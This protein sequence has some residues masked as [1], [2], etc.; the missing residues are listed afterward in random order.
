MTSIDI[1]AHRSRIENINAL[2]T[3]P[4]TLK[5]ISSIIEKPKLTLDE[6]SH[7]ISNDPALASRVLKMVNSAIYGFPGRISSVSHA[8]MLLGLNVVKG[9][10]LGTSIFEIMQKVMNGLWDHSMGCAV[11]SRV[12]AEKLG[13]KYPEEVSVA[14]LLHDLGKVILILEYQKDYEESIGDAKEKGIAISEAE[15]IHFQETHAA[16]GM[17]LSQKWRFP[18]NLIDVI[19]FHHRPTA[20]KI[21]PLE[22]AIVHFSDILVRAR[23]IGFAGDPYVPAVHPV[24][25][26][27]LRLSDDDIRDVLAKMDDSLEQTADLSEL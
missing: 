5:R 3:V 24:A 10:L 22:T 19:A 23:G 16:V 26:E 13:L 11:A 14:G 15:S 1:K 12:I 18:V 17:W 21:A 27:M 25:F 6:L 20:A 9:L 2:P 7:F 4:G 8:I